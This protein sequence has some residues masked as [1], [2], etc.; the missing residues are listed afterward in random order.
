MLVFIIPAWLLCGLGCFALAKAKGW[1]SGACW[2]QAIIGCLLGVFWLPVCI[3]KPKY[4]AGCEKTCRLTDATF[5]TW[6]WIGTALCAIGLV[7]TF[8]YFVLS[9]EICAIGM[10][11]LVIGLYTLLILDQRC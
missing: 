1:E 5:S 10:I 11:P 3:S 2:R 4:V 6:F 8:C 7:L 9:K